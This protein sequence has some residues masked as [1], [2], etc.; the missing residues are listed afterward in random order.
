MKK[1]LVYVCKYH[2]VLNPVS[3]HIISSYSTCSLIKEVSIEDIGF[4]GEEYLGMLSRSY[5]L[6]VTDPELVQKLIGREIG[7]DEYVKLVLE[8]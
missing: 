6:D 1:V 8:S 4:I 2:E 7:G 5:E 3:R